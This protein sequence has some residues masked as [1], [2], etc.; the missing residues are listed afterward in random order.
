MSVEWTAPAVVLS[1][2][3]QGEADA[4]VTLMTREHGRHP[5]LARGGQSR[6]QAAL[7]QPGNLVE[8]RWVARLAEQLG[9][10]TAEPVHA[11]A[12]HAMDDPL[13]LAILSAACAMADAALPE[14]EPHPAVFDG[15]V[16]VIRALAA[17]GAAGAAPY[18]LWEGA[19]LA[20]LGYGLDLSACAA[21]GATEDLAFVS[22]RSGRAVS[23]AAGEPYEDRMLPLP[24]FLRDPASP[25]GPADWQ[26]GL[27][28]T[29]H[30]LARDAF[31]QQHRPL[32]PARERLQDRVAALAL[33]G[34]AP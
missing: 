28:I 10:L 27:A 23:R 14:R 34:G 19:L 22:P 1:A 12:A 4:L 13:A 29:G 6:R 15:L 17:G 24:G 11:A 8:A 16:E 3:P 21:T 26:R 25:S 20:E 5:G 30:F 9:A 31:G 33:G 18:V 7:W 2:R 32:P